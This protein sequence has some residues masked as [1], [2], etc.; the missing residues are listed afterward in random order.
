MS[1][2]IRSEIS[3]KHLG[4]GELFMGTQIEQVVNAGGESRAATTGGLSQSRTWTCRFR[5]AGFDQF[6][7]T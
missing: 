3:R 5:D 2:S 6:R 7:D 1:E 4:A